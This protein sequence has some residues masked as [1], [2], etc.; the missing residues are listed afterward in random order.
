M[1]TIA[2]YD[3]PEDWPTLLNDLVNLLAGSADSV[4]GAMRV[5]AEFV[6]NDLSED[7][8]LPVVRDL[9]PAL[10]KILGAPEVSPAGQP[11]P[12]FI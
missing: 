6:K 11:F 9:A 12:S 2:K 10:L 1:S 3:W 5:V 8:L 7:Q 4:H